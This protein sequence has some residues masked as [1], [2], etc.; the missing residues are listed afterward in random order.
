MVIDFGI[1]LNGKEHPS[2]SEALED[3][4]TQ[5][6]KVLIPMNRETINLF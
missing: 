5:A 4:V 6:E 2:C 1:M 3:T